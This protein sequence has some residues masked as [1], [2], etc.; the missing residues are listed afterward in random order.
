MLLFVSFEII[1]S[2]STLFN[3]WYTET[4]SV[5]LIN[6]CSIPTYICPSFFRIRISISF[7]WRGPFLEVHWGLQGIS[8]LE[9]K[10][11]TPFASMFCNK[12]SN[13]K[14]QGHMVLLTASSDQFQLSVSLPHCF[15]D[16]SNNQPHSTEFMAFV[17]HHTVGLIGYDRV[18]QCFTHDKRST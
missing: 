16:D 11:A 1:A 14:K 5:N 17:K 13:W 12:K 18:L 7:R 15:N 9:A 6:S 8:S 4:A 2:E 10:V 3:S